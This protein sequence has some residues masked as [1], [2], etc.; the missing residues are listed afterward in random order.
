MFLEDVVTTT[1]TAAV[2][3]EGW[4]WAK[5]WNKVVDWATTAGI[6]LLIAIVLLFIVFKLI[7]FIAKRINR[8]LIKK[9]ADPTLSKVCVYV[10][11]VGLKILVVIALV[12]YVGI[13]TASISAV[14]AGVG[15]GISSAFQGTLGN[16]VGG[17]VI[18]IMRPFRL[19]DFITSNNQ[20][21]TV[22]DIRLFYTTI[23]TVDNKVVYLPNGQVSNN[24]IVNVSVK[25]T[26]RLDLV[27]AVKYDTNIE[28]AKNLIRKVA[29]K[30]PLVLKDPKVF[31]EIS[32]YGDS[33]IK[34]TLRSWVNK[35]DYWTA[36][37][38]LLKEVKEEFDANGIIMPITQ[39]E[40]YL[41]Q[42]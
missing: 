22:E 15:L 35:G 27:F 12:A 11:K 36:N 10:F 38:A 5:I 13:P 3:E 18:V 17:I 34:I 16:V 1:T 24:A 23:V 9:N 4:T 37:F 20:S 39:H 14:L 6:R 19:G 40:V 28:F 42:E 21:G 2:A 8:R 32:E 29:E 25:D 31:V 41:K 26:R 7:N 33:A 30:N